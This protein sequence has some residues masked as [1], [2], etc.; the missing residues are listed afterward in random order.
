MYKP[1]DAMKVPSEIDCP[2]WRYMDFTKFVS[3]LHKRALFFPSLA[4]LAQTDPF[5]G[6]VT[7][8]DAIDPIL[9]KSYSELIENGAVADSQELRSALSRIHSDEI[10][11]ISDDQ[12][13]TFVNCWHMNASE[14]VAM[15]KMYALSQT[16]IAIKSTYSKLCN[17]FVDNQFSPLDHLNNPLSVYVGEVTYLDY[18]HERIPTGNLLYRPTHKRLSFAY[19]HELRAISFIIRFMESED[20][21]GITAHPTTL[22][23]L[24]EDGGLYFP[25]DLSILIEKIIL[26]PD[27]PSWFLPL[28]KSVIGKYEIDVEVSKSNLFDKPNYY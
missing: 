2:I 6:V 13:N 14:S 17:C 16:G 18:E 21:F 23:Q 26:A 22:N 8:K 15:W 25:V 1:N 24:V 11:R 27:A 7:K 3:L 19:E 9:F 28:L 12:Q 5:E 10:S 20:K 4:R